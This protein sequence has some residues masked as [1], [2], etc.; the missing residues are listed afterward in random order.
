MNQTPLK[1]DEQSPRSAPYEYKMNI[2]ELA[3]HAGGMKRKEENARMNIKEGNEK[4]R[5]EWE[6]SNL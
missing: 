1:R 4:K 5:G 6:N 2:K 3:S